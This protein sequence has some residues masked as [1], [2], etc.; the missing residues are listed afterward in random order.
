MQKQLSLRKKQKRTIKNVTFIFIWVILLV[1]LL[2][3]I[4]Y[5]NQDNLTNATLAQML[6]IGVAL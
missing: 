6:K 3:C 4:Y 1:T 5:S 2:I